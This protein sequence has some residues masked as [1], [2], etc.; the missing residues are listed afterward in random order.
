MTANRPAG[1]RTQAKCRIV[2]AGSTEACVP[3]EVAFDAQCRVPL[4]QHLLI[5]GAVR[6]VADDA[7]LAGG[8][9]F[10]R[11]WPSL[12][13]MTLDAG[14]VLAGKLGAA[15]LHGAAL[16]RIMTIRAGHL[17]VQHLVGEWQAEL[18]FGVEVALEASVRRFIGIQDGAGSAAGLDVLAARAVAGFAAHIDG[19]LALG[20]ELGVVS[21]LEVAHEFLVA[22]GALLST[23]KGR[24]GDTRWS[25]HGTPGG[26]AG[27]QDQSR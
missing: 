25:H 2:G 17:A 12:G 14:L 3:L 5:G 23:H 13:G 8:F 1:S 24:A 7:A 21:G 4:G 22:L 16:V 26:S 9:M 18:G 15:A 20:L 10:E 11:K 27:Y 6:T 19:V